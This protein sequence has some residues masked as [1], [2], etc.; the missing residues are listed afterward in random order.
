MAFFDFSVEMNDF[1]TI[2]LIENL[3]GKI[4][5]YMKK[6]CRSLQM[7]LFASLFG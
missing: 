5:K 7:M 1:Y 4:R 3:N 2:N 6:R